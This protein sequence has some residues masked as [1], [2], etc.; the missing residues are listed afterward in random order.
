MFTINEVLEKKITGLY[1]GNR[2]ILPFKAYFIKVIIEKEVITDFSQSSRV[3]SLV[4]Q[5]SFTDI[6][7]LE[8]KR[9]S[10]VVTGYKAI[11]FVVVE[12]GKDIFD[13]NNHIKLNVYLN[14]H[15][16]AIIE[17]TDEDILF[18]E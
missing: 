11:K 6:Y 18:I 17:K 16:T 14:N 8:Y 3:I 2:L 12:K 9:L 10:E 1:Y 4:E 15:H 13:F 5:E 7:F